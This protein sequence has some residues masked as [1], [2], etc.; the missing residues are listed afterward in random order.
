MQHLQR[1]PSV[2]VDEMVTLFALTGIQDCM[3]FSVVPFGI[4]AQGLEVHFVLG[5]CAYMDSFVCFK[6]NRFSV[7]GSLSW[8]LRFI[9]VGWSMLGKAIDSSI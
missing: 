1:Q 9:P 8:L 6:T 4:R 2:P 7:T 3:N 5:E